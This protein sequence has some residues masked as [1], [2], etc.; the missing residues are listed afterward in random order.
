MTIRKIIPIVVGLL[1]LSSAARA[2][3][4][5]LGVSEI[6]VNEAVRNAVQKQ[7]NST[8]L[9]RVVQ[10][11]EE[12]LIDQIN[13]SRKFQVV[14][15]SDLK[16]ILKEQD[17]V[18]SGLVDPYGENAAESFK[19][20]GIKYLLVLGIDNFQDYTEKAT[21]EALDSKAT[22]RIIQLSAVAKLYNTTTG[23]LLESTNL[24][25]RQQTLEEQPTF[26][27]QRGDL[28]QRL[29]VDTARKMAGKI[30]ARVTN[31]VFPAKVLAKR[32][33]ML[34][35]N[36]GDGTQIE[37]GQTWTV[38]SVGEQLVDP[39][40]GETLG[41]AEFEVGKVKVTRVNPKFSQAK[42]VEDNG[43]NKGAILRPHRE[44]EREQES[45][46]NFSTEDH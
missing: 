11:L 20:A 27:R 38:F 15:R 18:E 10:S 19:V 12:Q 1:V 33:D 46:R 25:I 42:I 5:T 26:S 2:E 35:I 30:A 45:D 43:I 17:L 37:A 36:R 23:N 16:Q 3:K 21:F 6:D 39:D 31:V 4:A 9:D 13:R 28:T 8:S 14:A 41:N 7:G 29:F 44:S 24:Q 32:G 40:T 34:M 22:K